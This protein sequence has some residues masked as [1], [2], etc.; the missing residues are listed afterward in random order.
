[1]IVM[2]NIKNLKS[3][4]IKEENQHPS[5]Q[6]PKNLTQ[7]IFPHT[8]KVKLFKMSVIQTVFIPVIVIWIAI[9]FML[10]GE[11]NVS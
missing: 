9:H 11:K 1:M 4:K 10:S 6:I 2:E 7:Y 8:Q 3:Q 5:N